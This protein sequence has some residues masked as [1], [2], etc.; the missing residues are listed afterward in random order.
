MSNDTAPSPARPRNGRPR[1]S[2]Q[3]I[4]EREERLR[5]KH[6]WDRWYKATEEGD[7]AKA[8]SIACSLGEP[9]GC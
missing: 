2:T 4:A 6:L 3:E 7:Q 8:D 5:R 1:V 9:E